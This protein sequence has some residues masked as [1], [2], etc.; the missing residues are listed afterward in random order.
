MESTYLTPSQEDENKEETKN[1][2]SHWNTQKS[3]IQGYFLV[4]GVAF[5]TSLKKAS[6]PEIL[7]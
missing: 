4:E 6:T 1:Y 7:S 3:E 5:L 2:F